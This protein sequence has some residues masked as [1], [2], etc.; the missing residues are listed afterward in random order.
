MK[1]QFS[2]SYRL[3]HHPLLFLSDSLSPT[4][5]ANRITLSYSRQTERSRA[6][7]NLSAEVLNLRQSKNNWTLLVAV[8][9]AASATA[10]AAATLWKVT[11]H[12][13]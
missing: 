3:P 6:E 12:F 7:Q 11:Q 10:T 5:A 8:A 13:K 4:L 2:L 1:R 9:V